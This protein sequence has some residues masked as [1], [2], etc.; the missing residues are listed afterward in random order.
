MPTKGKGKPKDPAKAKPVPKK[1]QI[2]PEK[3]KTMPKKAVT[4]PEKGLIISKNDK[5]EFEKAKIVSKKAKIVPKKA[6]T[7]EDSYHEMLSDSDS[8][9]ESFVCMVTIATGKEFVVTRNDIYDVFCLPL[10]DICVPELNKNSKDESVDQRI[11]QAWRSDYGLSAPTTNRTI[12]LKLLKAVEKVDEIKTFDW[13]SYALKKLKKDVQKYKDDETAQNT[14]VKIKKRIKLEIKAGGYG[15]GLLDT[16]TYPVSQLNF[17][18]TVFKPAP[19]LGY[20]KGASTSGTTGRIVAFELPE[21]IM[22]DEEIKEI[23]TDSTG[24]QTLN[25][26]I[27]S[28]RSV[29]LSSDD[30]VL[31]SQTE[32][33]LS[34]PHYLKILDGLIDE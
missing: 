25:D 17:R 7:V 4:I 14:D 28:R 18:E 20:D 27:T 32:Q 11:I 3:S 10:S 8:D 16:F 1:T 21:G 24:F 23:S 5:P 22:T 26:L 13:C 31:V 6:K 30:S 19:T 15:Q 2:D 33:L 9:S 12:S 29:S 34:N